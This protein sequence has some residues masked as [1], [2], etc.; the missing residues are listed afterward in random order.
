MSRA[1]ESAL[2]STAFCSL[3]SPSPGSDIRP[4]RE[5]TSPA[6]STATIARETRRT[7]RIALDRSLASRS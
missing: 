7:L 2:L 6:S 3:F 4:L 1:Q 5:Q